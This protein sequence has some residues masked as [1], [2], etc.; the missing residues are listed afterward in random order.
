MIH[1]TRFRTTSKQEETFEDSSQNIFFRC[2]YA[3]GTNL[4]GNLFPWHW[5]SAFEIDLV[6]GCD[7]K[8]EFEGT[9]LE[10]PAGDAIFINSQKIH[11]YKLE[12][13]TKCRI[14]ALL[15]DPVL[16][17][18][19]YNGEIFQ[20][21]I[22]PVMNSEISGLKI[23][24]SDPAFTCIKKIIHLSSQEPKYYEIRVRTQLEEFWC[25]LLDKINTVQLKPSSHKEDSARIK[26]MLN[27]IHIHYTE[28]LSL[29][30]I[31]SAASVGTRECNRCFQRSIRQSPM[32]YVN[33][34][35]IQIALE[36]LTSTNHTITEISELCGFSSLSYFGKVFRQH[37]GVTPIQYR[38]NL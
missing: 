14:Y 32:D 37:I 26:K 9:T 29:D 8:F 6:T 13:P 1:K 3:T 2:L 18:G 35:R 5:H 23:P 30:K 33:F 31:A 36:L 21:Y 17:A 38:N 34:Y 7:A 16:L 19:Q 12:N 10:I 24:S 20:K 25:N 11:S 22:V 28:R 27:Y 15:F 4:R